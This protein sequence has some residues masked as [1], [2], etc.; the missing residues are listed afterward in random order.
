V[1]LTCPLPSSPEFGILRFSTAPQAGSLPTALLGTSSTVFS[2]FSA[3]A[4]LAKRMSLTQ[5]ASHFRDGQLDQLRHWV[6]SSLPAAKR[7]G[8]VPKDVVDT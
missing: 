5:P 2:P 1:T 4:I 3:P 8:V 7:P 6:F